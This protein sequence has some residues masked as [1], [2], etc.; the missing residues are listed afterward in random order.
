MK[1][2]NELASKEEANKLISLFV[3]HTDPNCRYYHAKQCA[4]KCV[5]EI[6]K[7]NSEDKDFWRMVR[8]EIVKD[9]TNKDIPYNKNIC[10]N[11]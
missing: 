2:I 10:E 9:Q 8:S 1:F 11:S 7:S 6:I 3:P 5:D 4:L